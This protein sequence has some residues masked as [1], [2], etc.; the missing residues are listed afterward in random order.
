VKAKKGNA[1]VLTAHQADD[2]AETVLWRILTGNARTHAGGI[3][4]QDKIELRPFLRIRKRVLQ[5]YL[6][7]EGQTWREDAT[8][9]EGRF[10]RSRLRLELMPIIE[11]LF[12]RAVEHLV[13]IALHSQNQNDHLDEA[14][15]ALLGAIGA[16]GLKLRVK[17]S[18]LQLGKKDSG[19]IT[20]PEG[21]RLAWTLKRCELS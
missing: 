7:E 4:I 17:R 8:N 10:L 16:A 6:R 19:E 9:H 21:W 2:L 14:S 12:P 3:L 5:A 20:L 15:G 18:H 1:I 11:H 13:E